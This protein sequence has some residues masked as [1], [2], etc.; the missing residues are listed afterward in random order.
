MLGLSQKVSPDSLFQMHTFCKI[1]ER[2]L[3]E[4]ISST[5]IFS[6]MPLK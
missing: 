1:V 4:Y 5:V 2:V 3:R 6:L